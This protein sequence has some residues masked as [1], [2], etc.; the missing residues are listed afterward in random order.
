MLELS[1]HDQIEDYEALLGALAPLRAAGMR[2]AINDVGAG[3]SSLRHIVLT[4]PDVIKLDRTI[5]A[6]VSHDGVLT[7]LVRSLV[8][9]AVGGGATVG[10]QYGQGWLFGRAGHADALRDTYEMAAAPSWAAP[11]GTR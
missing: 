6:G 8:D 4:S 11:G 1:E 5:V 3:F 9:F 10:V 2:V 7:T